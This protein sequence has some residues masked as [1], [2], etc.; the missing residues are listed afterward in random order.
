MLYVMTYDQLFI[1]ER[2]CQTALS[3]CRTEEYLWHLD[4]HQTL[5]AEL[6]KTRYH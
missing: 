2:Y 3:H 4:Q 5:E 6:Q 1:F